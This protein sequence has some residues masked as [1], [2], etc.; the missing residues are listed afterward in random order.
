[1]QQQQYRQGRIARFAIE[2]IDA[3]GLLVTVRNGLITHAEL[4]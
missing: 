3:I 2:N 1:M 4:L